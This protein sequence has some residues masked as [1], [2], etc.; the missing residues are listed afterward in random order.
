MTRLQRAGQYRG[1]LNVLVHHLI[2]QITHDH[3]FAG[4][5]YPFQTFCT[6]EVIDGGSSFLTQ[7]DKQ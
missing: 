3:P 1:I 4:G 6:I 7:R 5:F 2:S